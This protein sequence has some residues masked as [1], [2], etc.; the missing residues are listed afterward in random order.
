MTQQLWLSEPTA[1]ADPD[2]EDALR[3]AVARQRS[4]EGCPDG[5]DDAIVAMSSPRAHTACP[6]PF[7]ADWL[8]GLVRPSDNGR[9]APGPYSADTTAGKTSVVYKAH[10]YP[11]KV[12]HPTIM[13]FILHY[14]EPGD[15]VLDGFAGTGMTGVAAQACGSPDRGTKAAIEAEFRADNV[16]WGTRRAILDDLSPGATFIAAGMN[17]PVDAMPSTARP[18]RFSSGSTTQ[19]GWMY[20]TTVNG[21]Q[22]RR[23]TTPSGRRSSPAP[24]AVVRSSSTKPPLTLRQGGAGVVRLPFLRCGSSA[25]INCSGGSHDPDFRRGF[26]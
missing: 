13:R 19:Y 1:T 3:A 20:K 11:T 6:N 14:T 10:N 17:L 22:R 16:R 15:V 4:V 9:K 7:I 5:T 2:G 21:E 8:E 23:S 18:R 12:P 24:T 25:R 26:H